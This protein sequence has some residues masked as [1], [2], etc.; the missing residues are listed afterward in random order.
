MSGGGNGGSSTSSN[1]EDE[2]DV[3]DDDDSAETMYDDLK[4]IL[5]NT[6]DLRCL[7]NRSGM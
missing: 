6:S 3:K 7:G 2:K 5:A 4:G 1:S